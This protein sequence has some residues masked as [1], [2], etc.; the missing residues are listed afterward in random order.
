M[1]LSRFELMTT[2]TVRDVFHFHAAQE[3]EQ[4]F[5][6]AR[7]VAPNTGQWGSFPSLGDANPTQKL[8]VRATLRVPYQETVNGTLIDSWT[9]MCAVLD[10]LYRVLNAGMGKLYATREDG[11]IVWAYAKPTETRRPSFAAAPARS[12]MQRTS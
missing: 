1:Y 4:V 8:S 3:C 6:R 5:H 10:Q 11:E 7:D 2:Q 9:D 12:S